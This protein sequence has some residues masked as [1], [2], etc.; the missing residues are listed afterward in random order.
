MEN[1]SFSDLESIFYEEDPRYNE[2]PYRDVIERMMNK[3]YFAIYGPENSKLKDWIGDYIVNGRACP[4]LIHVSQ[5]PDLNQ[6]R[7]KI[8]TFS[9]IDDYELHKPY[10][11]VDNEGN[12]FEVEPYIELWIPK[13]EVIENAN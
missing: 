12:D 7:G 4:A 2:N 5:K 10:F 1:I 8:V 6:L 13:F 11:D 3:G 9:D